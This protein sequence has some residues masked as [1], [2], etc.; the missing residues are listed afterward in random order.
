MMIDPASLNALVDQADRLID[1][2]A[3]FLALNARAG[4]GVGEPLATPQ[5]ASIVRLTRRLGILVSR[6]VTIADGDGDLDCWVRARPDARGVSIT[7][8]DIR[9]RAPVER[10]PVRRDVRATAAVVP[11]PGADWLWETDAAMRLRHLPFDAGARHGFEAAAL[12]GQPIT[13]LFALDAGDEGALP[14][15][16]AIAA[17]A[18]FDAQEARLRPSGR[19]VRLAATARFDAAGDFAGFVGGVYMG[20][21]AATAGTIEGGDGFG[22][23]LERALRDP[24][25]RIVASADAMNVQA[26]GPLSAHYVDY[27]ADIASAGRHLLGLIDD[28]ADLNAIERDDFRVEADEI[29]LVD[30]ARRAAGLLSVRAADAGVAIERPDPDTPILA[31]GEFRRTLQV[32]V[33]LVGNAVRYSPRGGSVRVAVRRDGDRAV[34]IVADNGKGIAPEDQQRIFDKFERVDPSEPGGSGLG[35]YIARRLARA[36]GGDLSVESAPGEGARFLFSLPAR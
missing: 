13:W 9:E 23:R 6:A 4:G 1:G 34:A 14:L 5:L 16:E 29:D 25:G 7:L 12:L 27:A 8:A 26:D 17:R 19:A 30:V 22:E 15:L 35:L 28:L 3:A 24:L 33:N 20:E 32:L 18:D 2:D 36:M 11:P 21:E 10:A 31:T